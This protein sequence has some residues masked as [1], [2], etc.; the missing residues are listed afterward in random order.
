MVSFSLVCY[1]HV[2]MLM[3]DKL[4]EA[5]LALALIALCQWAIIRGLAYF[6]KSRPAG[7]S[8][9]AGHIFKLPLSV[10]LWFLL[11]LYLV[12]LSLQEFNVPIN[13]RLISL[14]RRIAIFSCGVWLFFRWKKV[15]EDHLSH[16]LN[17]PGDQMTLKL[18]SRLVTL[19]VA[20]AIVLVIL[21][22]L[23]V[24]TTPFLALGG[25]GAAALGLASKD[26][27]ANFCT[28]IF[29]S[30]LKPF[31]LGDEI[32]LPEKNLVGTIQDI[33]W[34]STSIKDRSR[35]MVYLPNNVFSTFIVV[36]N[37]RKTHVLFQRT[38][39]ISYHNISQASLVAQEIKEYLKHTAWIDSHLPLEVY[40]KAFDGS[41]V[42]IEILAYIGRMNGPIS[43]F[44]YQ[45]EMILQIDALFKKHQVT[46]IDPRM[47]LA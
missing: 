18:V 24:D 4:L 19:A 3:S 14:I 33:G 5:F 45:Q 15:L 9:K 31:V 30:C 38:F 29:L 28:G 2:M 10:L 46:V 11:G 13:E 17:R 32:F 35:Q 41:G 39:K 21:P 43:I 36:N 1:L 23:E 42:E 37:S 20:V 26:V 6:E 12:H 22:L 40:V 8:T 47:I 25:V 27:I 16:Q 44:S 34:F 7:S